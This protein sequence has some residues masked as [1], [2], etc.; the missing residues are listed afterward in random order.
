MSEQSKQ[1]MNSQSSEVEDDPLAELARIVAGEPELN[2]VP[3]A[4]FIQP[5]DESVDDDVV[6]ESDVS[7]EA[8]LEEQLMQEFSVDDAPVASDEIETPSFVE[9]I[10]SSIDQ[11]N[12][13]EP[14]AI[15]PDAEPFFA[16]P[17]QQEPVFEAPVVEE[18]IV[19]EVVEAVPEI[20][21]QDD[22]INALEL[23]V[24]GQPAVS[25]ITQSTAIAEPIAEPTEIPPIVSE[26]NAEAGVSELNMQ[27][28]LEQELAMQFEAIE[29]QPDPVAL[30]PAPIDT[31]VASLEDD[32]GAA[33]T[34]EFEQIAANQSEPAIGVLPVVDQIVPEELPKAPVM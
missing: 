14:T 20:A 23:E 2:P 7:M 17:V 34:N 33:F 27:E 8:A 19:E 4:D 3:Q 11:I 15:E 16:E 5:V 25:E 29:P 24:V 6:V 21:F 32:L 18:P 1:D 26:N 22:L 28:A 31:P 30:E 12:Q 10:N 13:I 9:D